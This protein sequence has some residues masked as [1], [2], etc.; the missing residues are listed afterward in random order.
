M[1]RILVATFLGAFLLFPSLGAKAQSEPWPA[2]RAE[3]EQLAKSKGLAAVECTPYQIGGEQQPHRLLEFYRQGLTPQRA[4]DE[5]GC[6]SEVFDK[7][8]LRKLRQLVREQGRDIPLDDEAMNEWLWLEYFLEDKSP[9][10]AVVAI[11]ASDPY[12]K[13]KPLAH[14]K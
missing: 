5:I 14:R 11:I 6:D 2:W 13:T 12:K 1:K 9:S 4:F 8:W 3:F 10:E 7:V